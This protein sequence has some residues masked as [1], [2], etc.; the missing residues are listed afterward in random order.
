MGEIKTNPQKN[1]RKQLAG[2][3]W[4]SIFDKQFIGL[5]K[6]R[7]WRTSTKSAN[8]GSWRTVNLRRGGENHSTPFGESLRSGI[9]EPSLERVA[10][11]V[12]E[13]FFLRF[14]FLNDFLWF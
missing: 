9:P 14:G 3:G 7:A 2:V 13:G 5:T 10:K 6:K 12:G 8:T 1:T 4:T 11:K